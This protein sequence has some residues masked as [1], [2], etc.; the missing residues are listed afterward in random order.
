MGRSRTESLSIR[1][2]REYTAP[3]QLNG[4]SS[5]A[6]SD[7]CVWGV[8]FLRVLTGSRSRNDDDI[9]S[10]VDDAVAEIPSV[11]SPELI[12][13]LISYQLKSTLEGRVDRRPTSSILKKQTTKAL[14]SLCD[15]LSIADQ[16][17]TYQSFLS[18]EFT[19]IMSD[20]LRKADDSYFQR[21]VPSDRR[22]KSSSI[23]PPP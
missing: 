9:L 2:T 14:I 12:T 23:T 6:K 1:G 20:P 4:E 8:T 13:D 21:Y 3:E 16:L 5:S 22:S 18:T 11:Q 17:N 19:N 10:Q 15:E 7:V